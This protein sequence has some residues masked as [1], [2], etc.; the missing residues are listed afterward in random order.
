MNY[1]DLY[2]AAHKAM[3]RAYCP[4]SHFQVGAALLTEDGTVFTGV[5]VENAS[6]G[7]SICA[8]RTACVK[9]V[10]EG[11]DKYRALAVCSSSGSASMCGICR[12]FLAEFGTDLDVITGDD[13]DHLTIRKLSELLPDSFSL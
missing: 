11:Y 9:A 8:E 3:A 2:L 4:Y 7:A 12:Q 10:S 1:R 5:N 13:A 6:Y